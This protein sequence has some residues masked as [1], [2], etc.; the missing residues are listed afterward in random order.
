MLFYSNCSVAPEA[1]LGGFDREDYLKIMARMA[2]F[3]FSGQTLSD[4]TGAAVTEAM[5]FM[6]TK[7]PHTDDVDMNRQ[8]TIDVRYFNNEFV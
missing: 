1:A 5:Q 8:S 3:V 4:T 6:Y 2:Q 7:W